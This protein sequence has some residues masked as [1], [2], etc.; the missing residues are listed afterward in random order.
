MIAFARAIHSL[1][2]CAS[3]GWSIQHSAGDF[4]EYG[5]SGIRPLHVLSIAGGAV[6]IGRSGAGGDAVEASQIDGGRRPP[7]TDLDNRIHGGDLTTR[8]AGLELKRAQ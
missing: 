1:K 6:G 2:Q 5:E 7:G 4:V 3:R 8:Q